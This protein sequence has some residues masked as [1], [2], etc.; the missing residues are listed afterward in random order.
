MTKVPKWRLL[1]ATSS[2]RNYVNHEST[3]YINELHKKGQ[4][5]RGTVQE[6]QRA[7]GFHTWETLHDINLYYNSN[8]NNNIFE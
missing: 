2:L 6:F 5:G 4:G 3:K 1:I 7:L 8:V